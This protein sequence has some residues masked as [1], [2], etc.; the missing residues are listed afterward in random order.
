MKKAKTCVDC[1]Y[2]R[3][4]RTSTDENRLYFCSQKK[5]KVNHKENYWLAKKPCDEFEDMTETKYSEI[6]FE[7]KLALFPVPKNL[8]KKLQPL[9]RYRA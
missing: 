4:S 3:V 2:C 9:L 8:L 7:R 6:L 5:N 1:L